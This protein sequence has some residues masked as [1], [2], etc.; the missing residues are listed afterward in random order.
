MKSEA[1]DILELYATSNDDSWYTFLMTCKRR[2][3]TQK[4]EDVAHRLDL[5]ME[6]L[7]A[8]KLNTENIVVFYL[9]LQ[10]SIERSLKYIQRKREPN[11]LHGVADKRA[12]KAMITDKRRKDA[13]LEAHI[14]KIRK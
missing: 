1:I 2:G 4:L 5:G 3:D 14:R 13:E 9:G 8:A 7:V 6:N 12:T 10:K 11:P